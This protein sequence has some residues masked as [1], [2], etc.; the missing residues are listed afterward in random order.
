MMSDVMS[1][2]DVFTY[3]FINM[4][5]AVWFCNFMVVAVLVSLIYFCE[6]G[7]VSIIMKFSS[8]LVYSVV[9]SSK[10]SIMGG[11]GLMIN[12][13]FTFLL[14]CNVSGLLPFVAS[15]SSHLIFSVSFGFS[16]WF[17]LVMSSLVMGKLYTSMSK[18][19][20]AGLPVV[21]GMIL[22]WLEKLSV[23]FRWFTLSLRLV[24]NMT[25]GQ[26]LSS[27]LS[28]ILLN[29]CFGMGSVWVLVIVVAVSVGLLLVELAVSFIQAYLFCLLLG[30]YSDDHS[31]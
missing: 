15:S 7:R 19:V 3:G 9:S 5:V 27:S 2:F 21:G 16:M 23:F 22:C 12:S 17:G 24:A 28:G 13:L 1:V 25:V 26:I 11:G 30:V 20:F 6:M 18:L 8:E 10:L 31:V 29:C 4:G 14:F